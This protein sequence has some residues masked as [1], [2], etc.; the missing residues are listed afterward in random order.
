MAAVVEVAVIVEKPPPSKN[1][2]KS[3]CSRVA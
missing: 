3:L 1:G 2:Q